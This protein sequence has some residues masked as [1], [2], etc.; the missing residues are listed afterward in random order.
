[1]EQKAAKACRMEEYN[2][3]AGS[4]QDEDRNREPAPSW[5]TLKLE[6][7]RRLVWT[8]CMATA[9]VH[10]CNRLTPRVV[11]MGEESGECLPGRSTKNESKFLFLPSICPVV[12]GCEKVQGCVYA[13]VTRGRAGCRI[14]VCVWKHPT[15]SRPRQSRS[16][17]FMGVKEINSLKT[18]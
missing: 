6:R 2:V 15:I 8:R 9:V 13:P 17:R 18:S 5:K 3:A 14:C 4:G 1:M 7:Q 10:R 16:R 12:C 11:G